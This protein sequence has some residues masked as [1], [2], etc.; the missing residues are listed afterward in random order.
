[1]NV[2]LAVTMVAALTGASVGESD[3][4]PSQVMIPMHDTII[5]K[6][7]S[8]ANR[9][10]K[11]LKLSDV[12][13]YWEKLKKEDYN[14]FAT[15]STDRKTNEKAHTM[16][17]NYYDSAEK[18]LKRRS[19][20]KRYKKAKFDKIMTKV[21]ACLNW[22]RKMP[23]F[24]V[25]AS[26]ANTNSPSVQDVDMSVAN[27]LETPGTSPQDTSEDEDE[28]EDEDDDVVTTA[29]SSAGTAP[30]QGMIGS[31]TSTGTT[32]LTGAT[33]PASTTMP[34]ST[35]WSTST[36][37]VTS[38]TTSPA[39]TTTSQSGTTIGTPLTTDSLNMV[40]TTL[41][42]T[43]TT[44]RDYGNTGTTIDS[45]SGTGGTGTSSTSSTSTY[46]TTTE[47]TGTSTPNNPEAA[48]STQT[49]PSSSTVKYG[50]TTGNEPYQATQAGFPASS[51]IGGY[52][53]FSQTPVEQSA[54]ATSTWEQPIPYEEGVQDTGFRTPPVI[55]HGYSEP[56]NE[57]LPDLS[58]VGITASD[59]NIQAIAEA[60]AV[61]FQPMDIDSLTGASPVD[62]E[63][64]SSSRDASYPFDPASPIVPPFWAID[65]DDN[66]LVDMKELMYSYPEALMNV[67][68]AASHTSS[69]E[70]GKRLLDGAIQFHY[71]SFQYC[72]GLR[73]NEV[74]DN[75]DDG[76]LP[77]ND[78]NLCFY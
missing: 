43:T 72:I 58:D 2:L 78:S 39:T 1:M 69:D 60:E 70:W 22:K 20:K 35:A 16:I 13:T 61:L 50:E 17:S 21:G 46:G 11:T 12:Q 7:T 33:V 30:T 4:Q 62:R 25:V 19:L 36:A 38:T 52:D 57:N 74:R 75:D 5:P 49:V 6:W 29:T 31:T 3:A 23:K 41:G 66:S 45:T 9:A 14:K 55:E 76:M 67:A 51:S 64:S 48:T 18:C 37:A 53:S 71:S 40:P 73:V 24:L 27:A 44:G 15:G 34:T 77:L 26:T 10:T 54:V 68:L 42:P 65:F 47:S 32:V 59:S 63:S 8:L 28:D 56:S